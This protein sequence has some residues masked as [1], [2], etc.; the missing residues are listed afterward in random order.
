[1]ANRLQADE[2]SSIIKER[3]ESFKS[4]WILMRLVE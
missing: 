3:I 2:I 1:V 4:V